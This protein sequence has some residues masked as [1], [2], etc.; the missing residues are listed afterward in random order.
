MLDKHFPYLRASTS[1]GFR[2]ALKAS[3]PSTTANLA[4]EEKDENQFKNIRL[5]CEW[6]WICGR[7][8][9]VCFIISTLLRFNL[10]RHRLH[11]RNCCCDDMFRLSNWIIPRS[12]S[13]FSCRKQ[14]VIPM[15]TNSPW[16]AD[17]FRHEYLTWDSQIDNE[18]ISVGIEAKKKLF[19]NRFFCVFKRILIVKKGVAKILRGH[20]VLQIHIYEYKMLREESFK[21][22]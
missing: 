16:K 22:F 12:W 19:L 13:F 10:P 21:C 11:T 14:S 6:R 4:R 8:G 2:S 17:F 3:L 18:N 7:S 9:L 1:T 15:S 20:Q 5:R